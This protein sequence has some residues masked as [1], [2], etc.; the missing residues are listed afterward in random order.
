VKYNESF[1]GSHEQVLFEE[2]VKKE[3]EEFL[4]GHMKNYV[5][6]YILLEGDMKGKDKAKGFLN[7]AA[8]VYLIGVY[9]DGLLGKLSTNYN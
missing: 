6:V 4:L 8:E 9:E 5:K 2:I 7:K 3:E 1:K